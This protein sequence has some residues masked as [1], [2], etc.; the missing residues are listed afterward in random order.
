MPYNSS[1]QSPPRAL[2]VTQRI[3]RARCGLEGP[4]QMNHFCTQI[5]VF[6]LFPY[7]AEKSALYSSALY[8]SNSL[9]LEIL[10]AME[11]WFSPSWSCL[12]VSIS[13]I[14]FQSLSL[15]PLSLFLF[16][17][18]C[19]IHICIHVIHILLDIYAILWLICR[20]WEMC[21]YIFM[22]LLL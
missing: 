6:A 21:V 17:H 14:F 5:T 16:T 12:W 19:L 10:N 11:T 3:A 18:H 8:T 22:F 2:Y 9:C 1:T 15:L 7:T 13:N 4:T 20:Y